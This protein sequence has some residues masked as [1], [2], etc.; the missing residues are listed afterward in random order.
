MHKKTPRHK[1]SCQLK[2]GLLS[3]FS[4]CILTG[5][6]YLWKCSTILS[7]RTL[8]GRLPIQ[9]CL[10]SRTISLCARPRA[11]PGLLGLR[12]RLLH[13]WS[14]QQVQLPSIH[15]THL[16]CIRIHSL[17]SWLARVHKPFS[18]PL[19]FF[20]YIHTA[21]QF[22]QTRIASSP[23]YF[24]GR[25]YD[26]F[27]EANIYLTELCSQ[28]KKKDGDSLIQKCVSKIVSKVA[29]CFPEMCQQFLS[30]LHFSIDWLGER[31]LL[32]FFH[33]LPSWISYSLPLPL[34]I[35]SA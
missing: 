28:T 9:R 19:H 8:S 15:F 2:L 6:T 27:P 29:F 20:R 24:H 12:R 35:L 21:N 17:S 14:G 30:L 34:T 18:R 5:H 33:L 31:A 1:D 26:F 10:V 25:K 32:L 16:G 3:R 22:S 11:P 13:C 23:G 4:F 7:S